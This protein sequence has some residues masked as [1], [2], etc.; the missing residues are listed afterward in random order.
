MTNKPQQNKNCS[1]WNRK[2][3]IFMNNYYV[4][5][6]THPRGTK[7]YVMENGKRKIFT[8]EC[9]FIAVSK[10]IDYEYKDTVYSPFV[11]RPSSEFYFAE[12]AGA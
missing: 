7:C 12:K 4:F 11:S 5:K 2:R 9:D 6:Q 8:A 1:T 10:A 3:G